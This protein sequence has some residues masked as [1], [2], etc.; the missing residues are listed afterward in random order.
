MPAPPAMRSTPSSD[1]LAPD[2]SSSSVAR[3]TSAWT[4]A[5]FG[6][7]A[8]ICSVLLDRVS[9]ECLAAPHGPSAR[10][11]VP[12]RRRNCHRRRAARRHHADEPAAALR[13]LGA[14]AVEC[15]RDRLLA[16]QGTVGS[17]LGGRQAPPGVEPELLLRRRGAGYHTVHRARRRL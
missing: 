9:S 15:P 8:T 3:S 14:P 2:E 13:A 4:A 5:R 7:V 16:G 10:L 1:Q 12:G 6:V 11:D 17:A